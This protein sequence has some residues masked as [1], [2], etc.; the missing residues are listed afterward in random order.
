MLIH[1]DGL[2]LYSSAADCYTVY[3]GTIVYSGTTGRYGGTCMGLSFGNQFAY[4]I[5][6]PLTEFWVGFAF[7]LAPTGATGIGYHASIMTFKSASGAEANV[8]IDTTN[9]VVAVVKGAGNGSTITSVTKAIS[10]NQWHWM[11]IHFKLGTST[12]IMEVWVDNTQLI[13]ATNI[14]NNNAGGSSIN[15]I[16]FG[17]TAANS[18][19]NCTF[20]DI[21]LN[22][23]TG[24]TNNG[25]Q[26]DSRIETL[27]PASDGGIN[28]GTPS[29]AGSH[30]LMVDENHNNAGS[31]YITITNTSGQEE[32]FN[33]SSLSGTPP[34]IKAVKISNWVQK[35]DSGA[36]NGAAI[37]NVGAGAYEGSST[38]LSTAFMNVEEIY[39][40]NPATSAAWTYSVVNGIKAGFI[41]P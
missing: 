7:N 35:T 26:G 21:V 16:C 10:P 13:N 8:Q 11:D 23:T 2:D 5:V 29:T 17:D 3:S 39:E 38:P 33:M 37:I 40:L 28:D 19:Y 36:A 12:G 25:R 1:A 30:Y 20:D 18:F 22:D 31:T 14:N 27:V 34:T 9:S 32:L 15:G 41:V 6:S 4:P 24:S